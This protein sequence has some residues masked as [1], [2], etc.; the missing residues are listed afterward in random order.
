MPPMLTIRP[1]GTVTGSAGLPTMNKSILFI[2]CIDVKHE[3]RTHHAVRP[4][5]QSTAF[6]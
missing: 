4:F 1:E 2:L 6:G 5:V 3:T